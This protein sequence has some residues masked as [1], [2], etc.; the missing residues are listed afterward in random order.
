MFSREKEKN[1][2][3]SKL[4]LSEYLM[5]LNSDNGAC[6]LH[7]FSV[8]NTM[9]KLKWSASVDTDRS[10]IGNVPAS[11]TDSDGGFMDLNTIL[12][13]QPLEVVYASKWVSSS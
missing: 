11:E 2:H 10:D 4:T 6:R 13:I 9:Q 12:E 7:W 1:M 5:F 3:I 8:D